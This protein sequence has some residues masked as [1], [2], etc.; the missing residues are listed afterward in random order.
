MASYVLAG[1]MSSLNAH[2][3]AERLQGFVCDPGFVDK[4]WASECRGAMALVR[5]AQEEDMLALLSAPQDGPST[6]TISP[7]PRNARH[8]SGRPPPTGPRA[9]RLRQPSRSTSLDA[10]S[11]PP[12]KRSPEPDRDWKVE[13]EIRELKVKVRRLQ[14]SRD[15][16]QARAREM[17]DE[18]DA[19]RER[20]ANMRALSE[21][22][23]E[24]T[25]L[26]ARARRAE[27]REH[28]LNVWL[29][30]VLADEWATAD[31]PNLDGQCWFVVPRLSNSTTDPWRTGLL[32]LLGSKLADM[33][34]RAEQAEADFAQLDEECNNRAG[35]LQLV[36]G[37]A[38]LVPALLEAL[39]QI[40]DATGV[41][42]TLDSESTEK[43]CR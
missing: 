12:R 35:A 41:S 32:V 31:S 26:K 33:R 29:K 8:P 37:D 3:P 21:M 6:S 4:T 17:R 42:M 19:T 36:D 15:A 20:G 23:I 28:Q 13:E 30:E 27:S 7:S 34:A 16:A 11:S 38:K 9:D 18:L 2:P 14:D 1:L 24:V 10:P 25:M 5:R 39:M 40:A 43:T 22:E